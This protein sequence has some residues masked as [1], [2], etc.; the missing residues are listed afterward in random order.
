MDERGRVVAASNWRR[1][2]S[3][4]GEDLSFRAYFNDAMLTGN[5]RFF[6]IGTTR[7]EPGYYLSSALAA[8][9]RTLYRGQEPCA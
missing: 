4:V 7:S 8:D 2:D 6:G 9:G 3:Y 1:P 5:G